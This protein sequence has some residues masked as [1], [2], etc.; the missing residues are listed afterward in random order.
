MSTRAYVS[1]FKKSLQAHL[2][3]GGAFFVSLLANAVGFALIL[4]VW[5]HAWR[6]PEEQRASFFA[7]LTIA[8]AVNFSLNLFLERSIGE[9]IRE[10]LIATDLVKPVD[11]QRL[12]MAQSLSDMLFQ[13]FLALAA[14]AVA[15]P[16]LGTALAPASWAHAGYGLISLGLAFFVQYFL[17]FVFVQGIFITYQNYG[18]FATRLALHQALSGTFAPIESYPPTLRAVAEWLPFQHVVYTPTSIFLGRV[19]LERVSTLLLHQAL[20]AVALYA[21]GRWIFSLVLRQMTVQGG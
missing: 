20:W 1:F 13:V 6:G 19:P 7:Y 4:L 3:Y 16:F 12:Y 11:F 9:R 18:V 5:R 21:L 17:C 14:V 15:V 2:A 8:F 10:G